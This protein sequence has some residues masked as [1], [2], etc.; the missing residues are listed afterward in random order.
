M[1]LVRSFSRRG[2]KK[3]RSVQPGVPAFSTRGIA[4]GRGPSERHLKA[5]ERMDSYTK[6]LMFCDAPMQ[7]ELTCAV[8][9]VKTLQRLAVDDES[10][11]NNLLVCIV[12]PC[13]ADAFR[14]ALE[15]DSL[16][17]YNVVAQDS[18]VVLCQTY[19]QEP[20][21][22]T[23]VLRADGSRVIHVRFVKAS[24]IDR[25]APPPDAMLVYDALL[26]MRDMEFVDRVLRAVMKPYNSPLCVLAL[27][28]SGE[29][30]EFA[31]T[32]V[33]AAFFDSDGCDTTDSFARFSCGGFSAQTLERWYAY[34]RKAPAAASGS[35]AKTTSQRL[36]QIHEPP[37]PMRKAP[38][39]SMPRSLGA[40]VLL[41]KKMKEAERQKQLMQH[42]PPR[43]APTPRPG[44]RA[45]KTPRARRNA[46]QTR[47]RRSQSFSAGSVLVF[48]DDPP[49]PPLPRTSFDSSDDDADD[50]DELVF[51]ID[52]CEPA[53]PASRTTLPS[54]RTKVSHESLKA[55]ARTLK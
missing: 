40:A 7:P 29:T 12:T 51:T 41:I 6:A 44:A 8:W 2:S 36:R 48:S 21:V 43:K 5:L 17:D 27:V 13:G 52:D 47:P 32:Q 10:D 45:A 11:S 33:G 54:I 18:G 16:I 26:T 55:R 49:P 34:L 38:T 28:H 1:L 14:L 31:S 15:V 39:L 35:P 53:K 23:R 42:A 20:M 30:A 3:P 46:V 22:T 50:D 24:E 4:T 9:L 25:R 37:E 19:Q